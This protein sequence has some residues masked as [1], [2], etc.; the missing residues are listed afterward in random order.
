MVSG[1]FR[2]DYE[3]LTAEGVR[4]TPDDIVRLNALALKVKLAA[5]PFV[6]VHRRRVLFLEKFT[7]REPTV[8]H[9]IWLERVADYFDFNDNRIFRFVYAFALSREADELPNALRPKR[10]VRKV[11]AFARKRL[12]SMTG[13]ALA[14]AIDYILFGADWTVGEAHSSLSNR[15][16]SRADFGP[17]SPI[18]GILVGSVARRLPITL[19][20]AHRMTASELLAATLQTDCRDGNYEPD[21]ERHRALGDYIRAREEIRSRDGRSA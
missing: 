6:D 8:A 3:A 17:Q 19:A 20:D 21:D 11:F 4:F 13:A 7:L 16:S 5:K 1:L 12:L 15:S 9:E 18:L 2:K 14:D 10:V